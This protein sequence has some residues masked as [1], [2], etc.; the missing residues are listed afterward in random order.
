MKLC[1]LIVTELKNLS[2]A[3]RAQQQAAMMNATGAAP[4]QPQQTQPRPGSLAQPAAVAYPTS[5]SAGPGSSPLFSGTV[6]SQP[7]RGSK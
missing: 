3:S 5:G 1:A 7:F 2:A 6:F 4:S